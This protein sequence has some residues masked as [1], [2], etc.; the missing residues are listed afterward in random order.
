MNAKLKPVLVLLLG[1]VIGLFLMHLFKTYTI[2]KRVESNSIAT[3]NSHESTSNYSNPDANLPKNNTDITQLTKEETVVAYI[4]EN[5]Q[6]PPCYVKKSEAR[7]QG[8][9]P[10]KGN[11]CEVLP[12]KA[13]GG[14]KFSNR[15]GTLPK[16]EQ[17]FEAD[18]N[19]IC[20]HR[21]TDRIVFTKNG[22]VWATHNH[23]KS[24]EKK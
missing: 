23:Y 21:Q 6:L 10:S 22:E 17:Y 11:L 4:K 3:N 2:E 13:I 9:E 15:E 16:G 7:R 1:I 18:V 14:D 20:G 19:Y 24:F 12:G 5:H 8:W